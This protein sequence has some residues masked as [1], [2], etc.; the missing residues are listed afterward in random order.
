MNF[1]KNMFNRADDRAE[2]RALY[3]AIV[4]EARK[5]EWYEQGGVADSIDGRFDMVSAVLALVLIRMEALEDA[6]HAPSSLVTELFVQ[7]MDGQLRELGIGDIVVGKHIGKMMGAL[8]GRLGAYRD[9][10]E[11]KAVLAEVLMRNLY[12]GDAPSADALSFLEQTL[13]D[14]HAQLGTA[15]LADLLSGKLSNA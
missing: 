15:S 9:V 12:R 8:G 4:A 6:A 14:R 1:L 13:R 10:F 2:V 3:A 11:G 5:P 7:D